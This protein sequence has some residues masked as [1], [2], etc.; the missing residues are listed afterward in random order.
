MY[1]DG[2]N[3]NLLSLFS[4]FSR[5]RWLLFLGFICSFSFL[6]F[7]AVG[8]NIICIFGNYYEIVWFVLEVNWKMGR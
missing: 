4:R 8:V 7:F 1:F 5:C 3:R 2:N 6:G